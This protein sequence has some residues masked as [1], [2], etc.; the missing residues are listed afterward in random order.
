[1]SEQQ[2]IEVN[3]TL[4][5]IAAPGIAVLALSLSVAACG[6]SDNNNSGDTGSTSS[7]LSGK[8]A[9]GGSSAQEV[10]Q[11]AW[12][13][14]FGQ[15]NPDVTIS[16]DSV[17]SGTG[18]ENFISGAFKFAGTDSAM[19]DEELASAKTQCGSDVVEVPVY[20]SPIDVTYTLKGVDNLQLSPKTLANIFNG[21]IKTWDDAAIKA[22][23]PDATLPSTK[24]TT[25]HRSD[26]SGTT[27]NFTDYLYKASE[28]A[29]T[30]E[31]SSDWPTKSGESGEGNPGVLN[32]VKAGD[33]TIGYNDDS[34]VV[35]S[36]VSIAKI[37]V[38][39]EYVAPSADGAAAGLAA[40]ALKTGTAA[41]VLT[42]DLNR[43]TT[44]P[45]TYPIFMASLEVACLK[46]SDANTGKIVKGFLSY[47]VSDE[48]QK[49]A[50]ANAYSA[51]LPSDVA[52][53]AADIVA[54][55]Q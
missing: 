38:G 10:A 44:D 49:A 13:A 5:R 16:Y 14:G 37:K 51:P 6:S 32:A 25:V 55:I 15:D 39:S 24:I 47:M 45:S 17:G 9:G 43:T 19:S 52:A 4:R 33:G 36:G 12:R 11:E 27:A 22:D 30:T 50:A 18:R 20:I 46:Y 41:S 54:Q 53:K 28:G 2:E 34:V 35:N 48:G 26:S 40:S 1:V 42:Y 21:T 8:V 29:W 3:R 7:G 23:N 31:G